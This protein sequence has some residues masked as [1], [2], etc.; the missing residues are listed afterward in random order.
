MLILQSN[1]QPSVI[2]AIAV[3]VNEYGNGTTNKRG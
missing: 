3:V 1:G 2:A